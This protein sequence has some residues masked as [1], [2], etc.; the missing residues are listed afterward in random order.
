[1]FFTGLFST[2]IPYIILFAVYSISFGIYSAY[3]IN[4]K[5]YKKE[6]SEKIKFP[7]IQE[8]TR[9]NFDFQNNSTQKKIHNNSK[10]S[11]PPN[12]SFKPFFKINK[13]II[14]PLARIFGQDTDFT[15]FSRPPP[16]D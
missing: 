12:L 1:M 13:H 10:I 8:L 11:I 5:I 7:E 3:Y 16:G 6:K 15:L 2:H 14:L 4:N 9:N